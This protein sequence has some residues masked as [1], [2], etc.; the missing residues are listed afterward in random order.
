MDYGEVLLDIFFNSRDW[1]HRK[2]HVVDHLTPGRLQAKVSLDLSVPEN[3]QLPLANDSS[4]VLPVAT[5]RKGILRSWWIRENSVGPLMVLNRLESTDLVRDMFKSLMLRVGVPTSAN[6][7]L[8]TMLSF[9]DNSASAPKS[10][11][12][13]LFEELKCYEAT[14]DAT[15]LTLVRN[16]ADILASS[17]L[18]FIEVPKSWPGKRLLVEYGYDDFPDNLPAPVFW[19]DNDYYE[20]NL[21]DHGFARSQHYE[22]HVPA[23]LVITEIALQ[24]QIERHRFR[25]VSINSRRGSCVARLPGRGLE[26]INPRFSHA[27]L[28]YRLKPAGRGIRSFTQ[29]AASAIL[30]LV[31]L[32]MWIRFGD[33][34]LFLKPDW[35][36]STSVSVILAAPALLLS[37]VARIP[38]AAVVG[39]ALLRL[40]W[41]NIIL[42]ATALTMA[43]ALSTRWSAD[44][45][46]TIWLTVYLMMGFVLILWVA[47]LGARRPKL[48]VPQSPTSQ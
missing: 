31:L 23:E 12:D 33:L 38:E 46:S 8:D 42:A 18:V 24:V 44:A 39:R 1:V 26:D 22:I 17:W 11:L 5:L 2:V 19:K 13:D 45:W 3:N 28:Y 47:E 48:S 7:S 36:E 10:A 29:V 27:G 6:D 41:I 9:I 34:R 20:H 4:P 40:R 14:I 43:A 30:C 15:L 37:W 32:S 16:F 35:Y 21:T 25:R